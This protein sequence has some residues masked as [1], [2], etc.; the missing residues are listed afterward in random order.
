MIQWKIQSHTHFTAS[1]NGLE[2]DLR[3]NKKF[4]PTWEVKKGSL[5]IVDCFNYPP[6][7]CELSAKVQIERLLPKIEK[8]VERREK[9]AIFN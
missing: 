7:K 1:V 6:T 3:I 8:E 5:L 2:I 9:E 4:P